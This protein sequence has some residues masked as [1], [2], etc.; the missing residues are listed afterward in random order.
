MNTVS[1]LKAKWCQHTPVLMGGRRRFAV[2]CPLVDTEEG[3]SVL[4]EVRAATLRRQPGEVCVPGGKI[5]PGETPIECAL[6]ETQ[7]ELAIPASEIEILGMGDFIAHHAGFTIQPVLCKISEAGFRAMHPSPDE[8]G[9]VFTVPVSYLR[10]H[11]PLDCHYDLQPV[12][13]E[14]FPSEK[15]GYPN[16]YNWPIGQVEIPIWQYKGHSIWGMTARMVYHFVGQD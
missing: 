9:E 16:G 2:V 5:E 4:F 11:P 10:E 6:R 14:D 3:L 15:I 13:P 7:E 1:K 12:T 8:V